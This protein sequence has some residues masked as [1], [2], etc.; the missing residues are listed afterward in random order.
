MPICRL[1]CHYVPVPPRPPRRPAPGRPLPVR[2]RHRADGPCRDRRVAVG[3]AGA[4]RL[5]QDRHPVRAR[6]EHRRPR[7]AGL[8]DPA[9]AEAGARDR[10]QRA[11]G[12]AERPTR[13]LAH[14]PADRALGRGA[15]LRLRPGAAGD[16]HRALHRTQA[17]TGA[18]R[19]PHDR[20]PRP[21][22]PADLGGPH[23][24]RGHG[25]DHR[26]V[27]RRRRRHRNARVRAAGRAALQPH[28]PVLRH[29]AAGVRTSGRRAGG[30]TRRHGGA[31]RSKAPAS[32]GRAWASRMPSVSTC[33]TASCSSPTRRRARAPSTGRPPRS[34]AA[35]NRTAP[36]P[37]RAPRRARR[38]SSP[39]TGSTTA[40]PAAPGA[41][42]RGARSAAPR[43]RPRLGR[44]RRVRANS[45][46]RGRR[47]YARWAAA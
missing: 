33:E 44:G 4:G 7:G 5:V 6:D 36:P 32:V 46:G 17:G 35:R 20:P 18:A 24:H 42:A 3:R 14:P 39:H 23:G 43:R 22:R 13:P 16:R 25:A 37:S 41:R 12:R 21:H 8:L 30:R 19:R 31:R 47:G 9:A 45:C 29:P 1:D 26:L 27:P 40:S 2:H 38:G 34:C 15:A 28:P 10:A 11:A